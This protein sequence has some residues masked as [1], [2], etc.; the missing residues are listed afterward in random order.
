MKAELWVSLSRTT[1]LNTSYSLDIFAI[2]TGD[3]RVYMQDFYRLADEYDDQADEVQETVC[4]KLVRDMHYEA[5]IQC[6]LNYSALK[7]GQKMKKQE[8]RTLKLTRAQYLE[9]KLDS[10]SD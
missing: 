3:H 10:F 2:L 1:L 4:K 9:V 8:A 7:M 5:Q 6:V